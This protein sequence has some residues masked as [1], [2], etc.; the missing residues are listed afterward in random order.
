MGRSPS[1]L[2]LTSQ[3]EFDFR[4]LFTHVGTYH[5]IIVAI[6]R[7][8]KRHVELTRSVRK[9]LKTVLYVRGFSA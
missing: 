7:V 8:N 1:Q 9:E 5:G 6:R 2:S 3:T 4:Q